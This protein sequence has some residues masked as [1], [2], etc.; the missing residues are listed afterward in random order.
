MPKP[1][2][3][4]DKYFL[5]AKE[6]GYL[7]RSAYKLDE[8]ARK[9]KLIRRGDLVLDLGCAP[10]SWIQIA[11]KLVG[12]HGRV[13]GVDLQDV[14]HP[15][16]PHVKVM[17]GDAFSLDPSVLLDGLPAS[18][19][20]VVLSDMAPNTTGHG[21]DLISARLCRRVLELAQRVLR[22][23]GHLLMKILE[24][25]ETPQVLR[26]TRVMFRESGMT[27]PAASRNVSRETFIYG[28]G[29]KGAIDSPVPR[30]PEAP[31]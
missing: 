14:R 23:G 5:Q 2:Q 6:E 4:H 22:P 28:I 30:G 3:L 8:I 9:R 10:G 27:K 31:A 12:Q 13:L 17:K 20:D 15:F 24:G 18:R 29:F 16:P 1:R 25:S 11:E 26:E 7:A 21:D 19:F